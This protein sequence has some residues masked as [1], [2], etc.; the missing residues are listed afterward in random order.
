MAAKDLDTLL[1]GAAVKQHADSVPQKITLI[2]NAWRELI[3]QNFAAATAEE[4]IQPFQTY[5]HIS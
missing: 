3:H 1:N 4:I 2:K 5:A